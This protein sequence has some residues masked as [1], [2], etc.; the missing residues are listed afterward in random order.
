MIGNAKRVYALTG[1]TV[2]IRPRGFFYKKTYADDGWRGPY[3]SMASVT[4]ML[5]REFL[6]E[7]VRR[8]EPHRLPQ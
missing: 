5:A 8:D 3:S 4:L 1:F 2:E 7:I 6:R